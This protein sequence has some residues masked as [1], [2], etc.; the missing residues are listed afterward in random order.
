MVAPWKA[1]STLGVAGALL[2]LL[3]ADG[4]GCGGGAAGTTSQTPPPA[5]VR[6]DFAALSDFYAAPFPSEHRRRADGTIDLASFPNP[7]LVGLVDKIAA[8]VGAD[9]DGFGATSGVYFS[10][11]APLDPAT[12]PDMRGTL[13]AEA[14]VFLVSV[15]E[16]SVDVGTRYPVKPYFE[17]DGGP[18]GATNQLTLLPYQG[19]ALRPG[20]L[21]AAVVRRS[22]HDAK[23]NPLG[24]PDA[25]QKLFDGGT[26]EGMSNAAAKS[27]HTAIDWLAAHG[28]PKSDIAALAVYRTGHPTATFEK[29]KDAAL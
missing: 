5:A 24:T 25:L 27:Y 2:L 14:P 16:A 9:A 29:V 1:L 20:T 4:D 7:A 12:L 3:G 23:G 17:A 22:V 13:T 28:V 8:I 15:D 18:F 11:D 21:Y 19:V 6:V 26:P 10:L